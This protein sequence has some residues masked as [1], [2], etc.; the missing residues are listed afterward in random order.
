VEKPA[1]VVDTIDDVLL[2]I[3]FGHRKILWSAQF[4]LP[5]ITGRLSHKKIPEPVVMCLSA[6]RSAIF[7]SL[8]LS[9]EPN[10]KCV[11]TICPRGASRNCVITRT[12]TPRF[13]TARRVM[14]G[15]AASH[16]V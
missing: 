8:Q 1:A 2:V 16:G 7:G 13:R 6:H 5:V 14:P 10:R 11:D 4:H 15:L 3:S 12:L 9:T